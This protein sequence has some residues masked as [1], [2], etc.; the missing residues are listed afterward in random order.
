MRSLVLVLIGLAAGLLPASDV[1]AQCAFNR[2]LGSS[3]YTGLVST[4]L[5]RAFVSCNNPGGNVPN[6][7]GIFGLVPSCP[8]VENYHQRDGSPAGGWTFGPGTSYGRVQIKRTSG[9]ANLVYPPT[10]RDAAI[11]LKLYH[12]G[13]ADGGPG[14]ASG[15]GSVLIMVRATTNEY[16]SG[17][18]TM[19]DFPLSFG[20]T[21]TGGS[22]SM[23]KKVG[24]VLMGIPP[25][26]PRFP[27]CTTLEIVSVAVKDPNGN[28]FA[29]PG[30]NF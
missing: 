24:D 25:G 20:F 6:T 3:S 10:A 2:P 5:V 26:L 17:D 29:V 23:T 7:V 15:S 22:V 12:I 18:M 27:D 28:V 1:G 21:L 9:G 14:F 30:V 19:I 13:R 16:E 11:V 4:S 8:P